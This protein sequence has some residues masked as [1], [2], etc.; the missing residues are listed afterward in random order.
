MQSSPE[1]DIDILNVHVAANEGGKIHFQADCNLDTPKEMTL[2]LK[3]RLPLMTSSVTNFAEKYG[4][5]SGI[6]RLRTTLVSASNEA[7]AVS[8]RYVPELSQLSVLYRNVVVRHQKA[9]QQLIN[10][11]VTFLRETQ[12][13]LPGIKETT[14]PEI[15]KQIKSSIATVFEE[16]INAI[17]ENLKL[18]ILPTVKTIRIVLPHG[19]ILTGDEILGHME[20]TLTHCVNM[21]KKLES[22]DVIL[23]ILGEA[24]Q[25]VVENT[26]EFI[27]TIQCDFLNKLAEPINVLYT[28]SVALVNSMIYYINNFLN[29]DSLN[30]FADMCMEVI[31]SMVKEF[32]NMVYVGFPTDT[33]YIIHIQNGRL[34]MDLTFPF[35]H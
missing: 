28:N 24:L 26:Q 17:T 11:A 19:E 9:I 27:D 25:K 15:C 2:G 1:N 30:A 33:K 8:F 23:E 20:N 5:L 35:D 29:T 3:K 10:A 12:I 31:L 21:V 18:H 32:K 16:I 14:L 13:K 4:I 7:Y 22:L 6:N 34:K